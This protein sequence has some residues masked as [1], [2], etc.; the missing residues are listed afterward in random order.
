MTVVDV[1][2]KQVLVVLVISFGGNLVCTAN[3]MQLGEAKNIVIT[4]D[5]CVNI[6]NPDD[7][8]CSCVYS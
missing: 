2:T 3:D 1:E 8:S 5:G 6:V 4:D 7:A